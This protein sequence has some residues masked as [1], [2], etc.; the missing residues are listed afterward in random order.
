MS[1]IMLDYTLVS[2][3]HNNFSPLCADY[4]LILCK[5]DMKTV[6]IGLQFFN[7]NRTLTECLQPSR[8][9]V[10]VESV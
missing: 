6:H 9:D 5:Q 10:K 1:V 7:M 4:R 8:C 2:A 3:T